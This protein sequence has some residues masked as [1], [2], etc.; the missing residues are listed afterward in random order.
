[1]S[2]VRVLMDPEVLAARASVDPVE[3][4]EALALDAR[5]LRLAA[6]DRVHARQLAQI[7]VRRGPGRDALGRLG[8][9]LGAD[10]A[11]GGVDEVVPEAD[12]SRLLGRVSVDLGAM[13]RGRL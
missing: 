9:R 1:M 4:G 13:L 12:V 8:G 3:A 11:S 10:L 6:C 7:T 5:D 2:M